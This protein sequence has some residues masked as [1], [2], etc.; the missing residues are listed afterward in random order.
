MLDIQKSITLSQKRQRQGRKNTEPTTP[1][2]CRLLLAKR[3]LNVDKMLTF[4]PISKRGRIRYITLKGKE[5]F[6]INI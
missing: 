4:I 5:N 6:Y 1:L 3:D 2:T